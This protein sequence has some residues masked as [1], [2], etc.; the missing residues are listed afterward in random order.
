MASIALS[1]QAAEDWTS[2]QGRRFCTVL[3]G[4]FGY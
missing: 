2:R 1:P 3:M 4:Q